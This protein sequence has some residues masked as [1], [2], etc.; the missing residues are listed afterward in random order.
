MCKNRANP[1][2]QP[3]HLILRQR[4]FERCQK[5]TMGYIQTTIHF[6]I[7]RLVGAAS[8]I[9][10]TMC[11]RSPQMTGNEHTDNTDNQ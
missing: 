8:Q 7:N 2:V 4:S 9:A 1:Q 10:L 11:K 3:L 5:H 6:L